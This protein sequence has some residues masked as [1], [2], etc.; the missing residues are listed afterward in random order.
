MQEALGDLLEG[1][2]HDEGFVA[3]LRPHLNGLASEKLEA[4][5]S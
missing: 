4:A 3:K 5:R 2:V 1:L